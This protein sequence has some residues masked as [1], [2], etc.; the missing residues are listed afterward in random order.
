MIIRFTVKDNDFSYVLKNFLSDFYLNLLYPNECISP[1]D[2]K[3][4]DFDR[5]KQIKSL[6]NPNNDIVLNEEIKSKIRNI[7]IQCFNS[8]VDS[9]F[10]KN[11]DIADYLKRSLDVKVLVRME[12]KWENGEV[13]YWFQ[14]SNTF[15]NQ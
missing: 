7:V 10:L 13:F 4:F 3:L 9:K 6:F 8:Y 1:K 2:N 12:D 14:H 15:L 11:K 5:E